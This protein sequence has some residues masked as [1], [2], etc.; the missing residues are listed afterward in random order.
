MDPRHLKRIRIIQNLYALSF[1]NKTVDLPYP[2]ELETEKILAKLD[3]ID[4]AIERYASRYP[5]DKI[6]RV[7]LA[8]L[9][10]SIYDLIYLNETP[11]K[12]IIN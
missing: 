1:N 4:R 12:I 3:K 2:K 11:K 6:A 10:M 7:D 8:I 5:L 9:R